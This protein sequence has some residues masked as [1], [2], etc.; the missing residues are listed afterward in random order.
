MATA[1]APKKG[2]V[3]SKCTGDLTTDATHTYTGDALLYDL[4]TLEERDEQARPSCDENCTTSPTPNP[5]PACHRVERG[6]S[7]IPNLE[8]DV[9]SGNE[10]SY[11]YP[12]HRDREDLEQ[13]PSPELPLS[14]VYPRPHCRAQCI[15]CLP[16]LEDVEE[17]VSNRLSSASGLESPDCSHSSVMAHSDPLSP[18]LIT[19]TTGANAS[20]SPV[21]GSCSPSIDL[22]SL[23]PVPLTAGAQCVFA[24]GDALLTHLW[25]VR[26]TDVS[27]KALDIGASDSQALVDTL[28]TFI[29]HQHTNPL[30]P[31]E[32][33]ELSPQGSGGHRRAVHFPPCL[34]LSKMLSYYMWV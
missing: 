5:S 12:W 7:P 2:A 3:L 18:G 11:E 6:P 19:C 25:S 24:T 32:P 34:N 23:S 9:T 14:P 33:P 13:P 16:S 15:V 26:D 30:A 31:F 29:I 27:H 17:P 1:T 21:P 8:G 4:L 20:P 10:T 22:C 28:I